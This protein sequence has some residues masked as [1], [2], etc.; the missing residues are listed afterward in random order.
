MRKLVFVTIV[1][2]ALSLLVAATVLAQ[3]GCIAGSV[4]P[5]SSEAV[6]TAYDSSGADVGNCTIDAG[7]G[8]YLISGLDD[9]AYDV[10]ARASDFVEEHVSVTVS[11]GQSAT[12]DFALTA[13]GA[14]SGTVTPVGVI[15]QVVA[16]SQDT[17]EEFSAGGNLDSGAFKIIRVRPGTYELAVYVD[18]K[19]L[20]VTPEA[21]VVVT[22]G[23][24]SSGHQFALQEGGSITGSV[25]PLPASSGYVIAVMQ[26]DM[27][28]KML[29]AVDTTTGVFTIE[30][31]PTGAYDL[32]FW[33]MGY[34]RDIGRD[35]GISTSTL[36]T[37]EQDAVRT[38]VNN[39]FERQNARDTSGVLALLSDTFTDEVTGLNKTQLGSAMDAH[40]A[41][42]QSVSTTYSIDLIRG[43]SGVSA[44]A[45]FQA[46]TTYVP[47]SGSS[48]TKS[49]QGQLCL[50]LESGNWKITSARMWQLN[51]L[52]PQLVGETSSVTV[53]YIHDQKICGIAVTSGQQ[54]QLQPW[55]ITASP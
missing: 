46:S 49:R 4:S 2:G 39:W 54:T 50:A 15:V 26:N 32:A 31:L 10:V 51:M 34:V 12:Q 22:A 40:Y 48:S 3:T 42:L 23:H 35:T 36:T 16:T 6:V 38:V 52:Y 47:V 29:G 11:L 30:G 25:T 41:G 14:I 45:L 37:A 21:G 9:G 24:I 5:S 13:S 20:R 18:A 7:S 53:R 33:I 27:K 8:D 55:T 17:G 44:A 28:D 19:Y 43:T 1:T